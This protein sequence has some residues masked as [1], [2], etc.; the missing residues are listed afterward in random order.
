V[1]PK[2]GAKAQEMFKATDWV[3]ELL[4]VGNEVYVGEVSGKVYRMR[5][6]G[7]DSY[8][9][10]SGV[11]ALAIAKDGKV[12]A[13][14]RRHGISG[15]ADYVPPPVKVEEPKKAEEPAMTEPK[16]EEPKKEEPKKEEPKKEEA[17]PEA[18]K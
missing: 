9:A 6:G 1:E 14:T 11:W 12:V 7:S 16:K 15:L 4:Q 8:V 13:G 5:L 18:A 17:K 3:T 10:P 2:D